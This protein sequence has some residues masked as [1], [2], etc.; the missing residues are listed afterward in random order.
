MHNPG[1]TVEWARHGDEVR[2]AQ[3]LRFDVFAR[4]LG[5]R[6]RTPLPNHDVDRFDDFC[7]H[8]LV[9]HA[10]S[11]E[12]IGTYR[13]LT[14]SQARLAGSTYAESEFDLA[15]L[16][17]LRSRMLELGRS[18]VHPNH[19]QGAVVLALWGALAQFMASNDLDTMIGCASVPLAH[20]GTLAA[21]IWNRIRQTHMAP[22]AW[23][24]TPRRPLPLPRDE[25]LATLDSEPPALI[26]GYLRLGARVLGPP[27]F[28][29]HFNSADLPMLVRLDDLPSRYRRA[30]AV[31]A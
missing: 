28:D 6:L 29:P 8:L 23:R 5:A 14:P 30:A 16:A 27:A 25:E 11:G 21:G 7:E 20:G 12:V 17:P 3:R 4:E 13:A 22:A 18:C 15:P 1:L 9:R 19:R 2:Q 24:V 31:S 10:A 26:R